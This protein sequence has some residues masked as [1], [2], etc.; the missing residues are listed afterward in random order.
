MYVVVYAPV[1][2]S[3][4][5]Y[6]VMKK[7]ACAYAC[8]PIIQ[9]SSHL[10]MYGRKVHM[11]RIS[12][13][14]TPS[15]SQT[16]LH[17]GSFEHYGWHVLTLG[18]RG[19]GTTRV[20]TQVTSVTS[21]SQHLCHVPGA[22]RVC[23]GTSYQPTREFVPTGLLPVLTAKRMSLPPSWKWVDPSLGTADWGGSLLVALMQLARFT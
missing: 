2:C 23:L 7:I 6:V 8:M 11:P 13:F 10:L 3:S 1:F 20:T 21:V 14:S 17:W 16:R 22:D 4:I 15:S 5:L 12:S 18:A 9:I 19:K